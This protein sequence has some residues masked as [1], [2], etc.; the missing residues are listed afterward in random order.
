MFLSV[1]HLQT[2]QSR[3]SKIKAPEPAPPPPP[4]APQPAP[5]PPTQDR[6]YMELGGLADTAPVGDFAEVPDRSI[7]TRCVRGQTHA[8]IR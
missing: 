7:C 8:F 1:I 5:K 2:P 3:D 6:N 4:P